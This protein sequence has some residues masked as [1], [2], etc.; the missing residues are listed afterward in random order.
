MTKKTHNKANEPFD[1]FLDFIAYFCTELAAGASPEYALGRAIHY[2]GDQSPTAF[3]RAFDGIAR[4]TDSFASAWRK[5]IQSYQQSGQS[6]LLELLSQFLEKGALVG[7]V[8]ML[9]VVQQIRRN[10]AL[11]KS[12]KN[13]IDAQRSKL[14]ALSIVSSAV[15]GMVAAIAPVLNPAFNVF[16]LAHQQETLSATLHVSIALFLTAIVSTY[17]LSQT[18][19]GSTRMLLLCSFSFCVTFAL[20]ANLLTAIP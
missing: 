6:R 10:T 3:N 19:K 14:L 17:R 15:L 1:Q 9:R 4:G 18:A 8:R 13:L 12:R 2:Y 5:V 16:D 20:T 7:G 11:A